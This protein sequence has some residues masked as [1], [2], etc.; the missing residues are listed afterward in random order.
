MR[1]K[2]KLKTVTPDAIS[3]Q[4]AELLSVKQDHGETT[5]SFYAKVKGKAATCSYSQVMDA[6]KQIISP[7][8][9]KVLNIFSISLSSIVSSQIK[10][11]TLL[12]WNLFTTDKYTFSLGKI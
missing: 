4:R 1:S 6:G 12:T 9:Q 11:G 8:S 5:R 2:I 10:S 3:V 7:T